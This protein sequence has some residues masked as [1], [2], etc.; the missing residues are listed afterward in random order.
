MTD[1]GNRRNIVDLRIL[2]VKAFLDKALQTSF[3]EL[4]IIIVKVVPAHLVDSQ[5]YNEFGPLHL[6]RGRHCDSK[7]QA[8]G[9]QFLHVDCCIN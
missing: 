4:I 2:T 6:S 5:A 7:Q 8:N 3:S 1:S 9:K